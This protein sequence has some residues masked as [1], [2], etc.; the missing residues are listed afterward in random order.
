MDI[1]IFKTTLNAYNENDKLIGSVYTATIC[2]PPGLYMPYDVGDIVYLSFVNNEMSEPVILGLVHKNLPKSGDSSSFAY[3]KD[4]EVT[5]NVKLPESTT[6]GDVKLKKIMSNILDI[7]NLYSI[8]NN[9]MDNIYEP[10]V[11]FNIVTN[12]AN[13]NYSFKM[14]CIADMTPNLINFV[15]EEL[16]TSFTTF[17][18]MINGFN[19]VLQGT[20]GLAYKGLADFLSTSNIKYYINNGNMFD[21][22]N[23]LCFTLDNNDNSIMLLI[24]SSSGSE[25][26]TISISAQNIVSAEIIV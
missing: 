9:K 12:D 18:E 11:T 26:Y 17:D 25:I 22:G 6:I 13:K 21:F 3:F 23:V 7:N 24:E 2:T 19:L 10:K 8:T 20:P 15:N 5:D 1:S 4:L 14:Y 16:E